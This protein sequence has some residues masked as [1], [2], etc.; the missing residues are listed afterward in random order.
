MRRAVMAALL[1]CVAVCS[2][3]PE[4]SSSL[5][6]VSQTVGSDEL[7]LALARPEQ[8]AALSRFAIEPKYSA[9]AEQAE[10]HPRL[11]REDN[12]EGILKFRP[13]LVLFANYSR[14]ELITQVQR[15]G[16]KTLIFDHYDTLED[17]Y[18][19][20]RRLAAVLGPEA[21]ARAEH[22][23]SEG[24]ARVEALA[25]R[26]AGRPQVRVIAPSIY[27]PI[28][29]AESSFQDLCDHAGADNLAASLA[30]LQ[31]FAM[32]P[33]EQMLTWPIDRVVVAGRDREQPLEELRNL[34][35]YRFMPAVQEGRA[36]LLR[37]YQLSCISHHR[38]EGYEQLA[39]ELHPEAFP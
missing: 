35:P 10:N 1:L 7:L 5:R 16:I 6:V 12:I 11:N 39:R 30:H 24:R 37:P 8:I 3:P 17:A 14:A 18:A 25:V 9:V 27:G 29:G 22:I 15:A 32:P 36:A 4:P 23:E 19:N 34:S 13:T 38:I 21:Q 2:R 31:G 28:P 20:L 26:L 33:E